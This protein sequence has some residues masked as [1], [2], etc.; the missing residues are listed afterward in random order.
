MYLDRKKTLQ[1]AI[2]D[3]FGDISA[4]IW[5]EQKLHNT[6]RPCYKIKNF[7]KKHFLKK[8][9]QSWHL[10]VTSLST[11]YFPQQ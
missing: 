3:L 5:I 7:V 10:V 1:F 8:N 4:E 9:L 11:N 6:L 2:L